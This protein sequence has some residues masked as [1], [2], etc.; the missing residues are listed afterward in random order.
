M[1]R[2]LRTI[3]QQNKLALW[4]KRI[5]ECR[6][7]GMAVKVWCRENGICEQ[8]YYK[9]YSPRDQEGVVSP[10]RKVDYLFDLELVEQ[11]AFAAFRSVTLLGF[12]QSFP[13]QIV[14]ST[15]DSGL[16]Q[17]QLLG[18]GTDGRSALTIL[19]G[20]VGQVHIHRYRTKDMVIVRISFTSSTG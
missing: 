16:G 17:L 20:T 8:T 15:A 9:G 12:Q 13:S 19:V 3:N 10:W 4:A 6:N 7:S 18:N 14:E 1:S 2:E 5:S 11:A